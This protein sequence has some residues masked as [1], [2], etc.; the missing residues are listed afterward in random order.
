MKGGSIQMSTIANS[1]T[2]MQTDTNQVNYTQAQQSEGSDQLSSQSFLQLMMAQLQDQDPTD[3]VSTSDMLDQEAQLTQ[4]QTMQ[5]LSTVLQQTS[6]IADA[7]ALIGQNVSV[8]D[9]NG[10]AVTGTVQSANFSN[11]SAAIT[12]NGTSYPL[13]ELTQIN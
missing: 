5:N 6:Q 3:P 9:A 13:S 2:Q 12:I 1:I 4:V 10:D 7:G 11:G 8:T